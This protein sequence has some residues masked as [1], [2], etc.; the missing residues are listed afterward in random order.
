M[1]RDGPGG[2]TA[3]SSPTRTRLRGTE[4]S[5]VDAGGRDR[6]PLVP[7]PVDAAEFAQAAGCTRRLAQ[8]M[9]YC[10]RAMGALDV[11]ARRGRAVLYR[12]AAVVG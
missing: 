6:L 10:L 4:H 8:Q 5:G 3:G 11:D 2:G 1:N 7:D 9:T 12:R